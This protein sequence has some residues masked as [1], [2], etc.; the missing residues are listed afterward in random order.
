VRG[1]CHIARQFS[2]QVGSSTYKFRRK[3]NEYQFNFNCRIESVIDA[4]KVELTKIKPADN[5]RSG[6]KPG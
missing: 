2:K 3:G 5:D 1:Q 6:V 4:A